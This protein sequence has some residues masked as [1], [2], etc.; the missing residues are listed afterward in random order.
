MAIDE[1]TR[2]AAIRFGQTLSGNPWYSSVGI[3]E[4]T[5][6]EVLIVYFRRLP[7]NG[8]KGIPKEWEGIPVRLQS[9]GKAVAL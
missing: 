4:N 3:T 2:P 5:G 1:K 8:G 6:H 9:I 7:P